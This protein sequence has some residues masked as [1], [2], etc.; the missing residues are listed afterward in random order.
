[1]IAN[2]VIYVYVSFIFRNYFSL[3]ISYAINALGLW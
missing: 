1:M 2:I 3:I